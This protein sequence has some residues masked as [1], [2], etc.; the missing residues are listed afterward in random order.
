MHMSQR[1]HNPGTVVEREGRR[2]D[3]TYNMIDVLPDDSA[4]LSKAK[5]RDVDRDFIARL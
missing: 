5:G 2:K 3:R 1:V 4:L